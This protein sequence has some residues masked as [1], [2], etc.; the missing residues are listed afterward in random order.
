MALADLEKFQTPASVGDVEEWIGE[1]SV[2][3]AG[4]G[5]GGFDAALLISA[6]SVR[7]REYPA[8]VVRQAL[9]GKTWKWFPAWDELKKVC[10]SLASP[11]RQMIAA[12]K[13]PEREAEPK[14]RPPTQDEKDRIAALVAEKFP[15]ASLP[16]RKRAV[17]EVTLGACI[18][19]EGAVSDG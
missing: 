13:R 3:T 9:L 4:K 2:L 1:L 16:W 8:D 5:V 10:D 19:E 7:L 17:E 14:R 11:R 12:L 15:D 18:Q 6:Y